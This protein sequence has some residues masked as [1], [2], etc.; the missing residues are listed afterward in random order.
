VSAELLQLG[1]VLLA[2][3]AF[4]LRA[5]TLA[6]RGRPVRPLHAAFF[7]AGLA[8]VVCAFVSPLDRLGEER[9]FSAHMAQHLLLGDLGPLLV[10]LGLHGALLRPL[11]ALPA[12]GRL[13]A[14]AHPA[15]AL[16][17][18]AANLYLW[19]LPPLYDAALAH[20]VVHALQHALFF[21]SGA[22]LWSALVEPLPGPAWFGPGWKALYSLCAGALGGA[23]ANVFIWSTSVHYPRY[24]SLTD[25][26]LGGALMLLEGAAV[27]LTAFS[28]F[29][30]RWMR[31][32]EARERLLQEGHDPAAVARA[33]RYGR[34][35]LK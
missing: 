16:P 18:W 19:H 8:V 10:V 32:A 15:V 30:L 34:L 33:L 5:R 7:S 35:V 20:D 9:F 2:A 6:R 17:V 1:A 21:T 22:L 31:D 27:T 11:L 25:Q 12:V 23:L 14:L 24:P 26:R 4:A 28:W 3:G 13:R 29:F